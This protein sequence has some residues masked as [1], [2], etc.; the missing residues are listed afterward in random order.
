V[1]RGFDVVA[2]ATLLL[3]LGPLLV[4]IAAIVRLAMGG[5]VIYRQARIGRGGRPFRMPKVRSMVSG[6][7]S[8]GSIAIPGDPRVTELGARLRRTRLDELPQLWSVL[9]GDMSMV[10]PRPD[11]P[12]YADRLRGSDRRILSLR[13]GIT[14]PATL[15]FRDEDEIL[16]SQTDPLRFNDEI[17]Y[18]AKT[19]INIAYLEGWSLRLDIACLLAT[20]HPAFERSLPTWARRP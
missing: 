12:G 20:L 6:S 1:K 9:K 3:V 17:L 4:C 13:P 8:F 15:R 7:E 19:R 11:V 18:P 14:G 2:S 16:A 5:P 10:G